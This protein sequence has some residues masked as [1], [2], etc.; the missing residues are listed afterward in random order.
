MKW[1]WLYKL[2]FNKLK[3]MGETIF[4]YTCWVIQM[5]DFI[6]VFINNKAHHMINV[7]EHF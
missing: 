1:I 2:V 7:L 3:V 4:V 6:E 5:E